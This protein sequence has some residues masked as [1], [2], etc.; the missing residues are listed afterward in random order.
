MIIIKPGD[1]LYNVTKF[2]HIPL[3]DLIIIKVEKKHT[4]ETCMIL[5]NKI[6][7]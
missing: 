4:H 7:Y 2:F 5:H 1:E 6:S 3:S